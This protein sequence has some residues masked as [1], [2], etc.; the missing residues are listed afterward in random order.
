M[1]LAA[2]HEGTE[3]AMLFS[4]KS[5][6]SRLFLGNDTG[7]LS[8]STWD[9]LRGTHH[10][11]FILDCTCGLVDEK[12]GHLGA[13]A[14]LEMRKELL[15]I[16][17]VNK[18]TVFIANHFSHNGRMLHCDLEEYFAPHGILVGFDGMTVNF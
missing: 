18:K 8:D 17:A 2:A 12:C 3:E 6:K 10:D 15:R 14:F 4:I 7:W 5:E 9:Y 13:A 16:G 1:P 11:T